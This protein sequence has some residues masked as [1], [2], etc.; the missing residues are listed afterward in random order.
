[1]RIPHDRVCADA[2]PGLILS[3]SALPVFAH[4]D[5]K[6]TA[7]RPAP[8]ANL[9]DAQ[10]RRS[11]TLTRFLTTASTTLKRHIKPR[12]GAKIVASQC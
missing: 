1:M 5:A 7:R 4:R 12:K 6:L 9:R 10:Q 3:A 11:V 8:S 2:A